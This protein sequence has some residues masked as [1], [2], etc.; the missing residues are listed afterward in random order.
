M[1][2]AKLSQLENLL[3]EIRLQRKTT[4]PYCVA[5]YIIHPV[6]WGEKENDEIVFDKEAMNDSF[7]SYVENFLEEDFYENQF[8]SE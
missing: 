3:N 1:D 2:Y 8:D 4:E 6:Y 7:Q 5:T